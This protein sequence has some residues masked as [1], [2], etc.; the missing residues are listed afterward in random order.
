MA[1]KGRS[2][3][4]RRCRVV[5]SVWREVTPPFSWKRINMKIGMLRKFYGLAGTAM[6]ALVMGAATGPAYAGEVIFNIGTSINGSTPTG[7]PPWLTLD[8]KDIGTN[9]V[10]LTISN[11]MPTSEFA[12]N[13][14]FNSTVGLVGS[15]FAHVSGPTSNG[16]S[17]NNNG[18][19]NIKAG[20]F[21]V[22]FGYTTAN[23]SNRLSGGTNSVYD[24]T[25]S[26]LN[27]LSFEK[28][29][30]TDSHGTGGWYAAADV[31]GIPLDRD[32]T[33]SGS[34]GTKMF[35]AVPE[36]STMTLG[37]L[38][39]PRRDG[40]PSIPTSR[41]S[42]S[43][44]NPGAVGVRFEH[45]VGDELGVQA[46]VEAGHGGPALDDRRDELP[47]Q[48]VAEDGRRRALGRVARAAGRLEELGGHRRPGPGRGRSC[49]AGSCWARAAGRR[50]SLPSR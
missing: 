26:G 39:T 42:L 17:F 12:S 49:P 22:D 28:V 33:T 8:F 34:A 13:V 7:T 1:S 46:V 23:N 50:P 40:R 19:N 10:Q 6:A 30:T 25:A 36:P 4:F 24:I 43:H 38:A 2:L 31:Q 11:N 27:A 14:L 5:F 45:G 48:V 3:S 15:D 47:H 9:E 41:A 32:D 21:N 35:V 16:I 44:V 29:S 37:A 18:G 20:Q